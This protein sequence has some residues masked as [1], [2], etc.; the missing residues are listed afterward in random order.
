MKLNSYEAKNWL[1]NPSSVY[2]AVLFHGPNQGL[3]RERAQGLIELKSNG[4]T[5]D[6]FAVV[7]IDKMARDQNPSTV[8]T[9]AF[10]LSFVDGNKVVWLTEVTDTIYNDLKEIFEDDRTI[11]FMVFEAGTL[12][13]RSKLRSL[14]E[15][16]KTGLALGCYEED[17]TS[18][19][20]MAMQIFHAHQIK[21]ET[22]VVNI[23]VDRLGKDRE[24]NRK[25]IE[26]LCLFIGDGETLTEKLVLATVT[27]SRDAEIDE[28]I[29]AIF[30]GNR[31][32]AD[33]LLNQTFTEGVACVQ[34]VRRCQTHVDRLRM[35]RSQLDHGVKLDV[36]LSKLRPTIFF[37][38]KPKFMRQVNVWT[39][40]K[41]AQCAEGL[42][43][44]EISCKKGGQPDKAL[45]QRM[46][47]SISG[48]AREVSR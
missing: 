32:L 17:N 5:N 1:H 22:R 30:D 44:L 28:S 9:E 19:A 23:L 38:L 4:K 14:F 45:C 20:E 24:I 13:P 26:K 29:Y 15:K 47:F 10:A 3:V 11:N 16:S 6:P 27:N 42:L 21:A 48:L 36:A 34:W 46:A 25:E 33:Q 35:V 12:S 37:K 2:N 41:L 43:E 8:F 18:I 31:E 40:P 39:E 7:R